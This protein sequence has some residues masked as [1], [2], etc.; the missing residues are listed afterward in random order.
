MFFC[1]DKKK[2]TALFAAVVFFSFLDRLL[3]F[4]AVKKIFDP[5]A[6]I[7]GDFFQLKFAG[8]EGI[9][10]SFPIFAPV[11]NFLIIFIIVSLIYYLSHLFKEKE[12]YRAAFM[13]FIIFGAMSNFADRLRYGYVVDYL[14]LKYFTV[15]NLADVMIVAGGLGGVIFF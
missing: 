6:K 4:L 15:F 9:A 13:L 1:S 5:P 3:K 14:N 7:F 10:F 2:T 8:N 11:L 12:F